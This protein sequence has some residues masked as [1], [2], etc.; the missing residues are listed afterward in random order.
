MVSVEY[1]PTTEAGM[2]TLSQRLFLTM[3][4]ARTVLAGV[5][6][7]DRYKRSTGPC[8]L[9]REERSELRPCRILNTLGEAMVVYHAIDRQI[10][11]GN[12]PKA[13]D[14]TAAFLVGKVGT[15]VS[16]S[17]MHSRHN[18]PP[19]SAFWGSPGHCGEFTLG[20]LQV[21][22]I[23]A[24]KLGTRRLFPCRKR[25]KAEEPYVNTHRLI[26]RRQGTDFYLTCNRHIPFACAGA[27]NRTG[28]RR[29]FQRSML[30]DP[31]GA[32][33]RQLQDALSQL[34]PIAILRKRHR[35][36]PTLAAKAWVPR[37]LTGFAA[38]E[39]G[40]EGEINPQ[41]H[42]LQYL[43]VNAQQLRTSSLELRQGN[44]LLVVIQGFLV[45][46]VGLLPLIEE[47]I[48][49]TPTFLKLILKLMSLFFGGVESVFHGLKHRGIIA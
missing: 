24:Q 25:R 37:F 11:D 10:F 41:C 32:N 34:T 18:P 15:A 44:R 4:T 23:G 5:R 45:L 1:Q 38:T 35:V 43:R 29:T 16:N 36:I 22:F 48:V 14:E 46:F 9:V 7:V 28:F 20:P 8:C 26:Y 12:D 19:F 40:L 2:D 6:R 30:D 3:T 21:L 39:K 27:T 47:M 49:Q 33:L 31:Y 17:F 13:I 42:V